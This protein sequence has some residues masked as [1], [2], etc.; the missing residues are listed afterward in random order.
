MNEFE[1]Q[2]IINQVFER[3]ILYSKMIY[4]LIHF[5]NFRVGA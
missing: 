2:K 1:L 4:K 3:G 5:K